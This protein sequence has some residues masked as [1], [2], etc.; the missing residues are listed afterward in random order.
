MDV[1][2]PEKGVQ[3]WQTFMKS[4]LEMAA[5][6]WAPG[7]TRNCSN[8]IERVQKTA[9][10]IILGTQYVSYTQ[11]LENL[12][13]ETLLTRREKLCLTF[14]KKAYKNDKFKSWFCEATDGK[15]L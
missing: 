8:Q 9:L 7:L 10:A 11:A 3:M 12:K 1:E 6:A 2:E 15:G 4:I 14:S 5:P 13:L